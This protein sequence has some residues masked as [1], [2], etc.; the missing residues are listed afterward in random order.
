[1]K[2][3]QEIIAE[4]ERLEKIIPVDEIEKGFIHIHICA[5]AWVI[6]K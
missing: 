2:T 4:I 3:E 1:M 5:L 6:K